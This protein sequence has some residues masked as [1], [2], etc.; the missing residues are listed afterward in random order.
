MVPV[1]P[2]VGSQISL[3]V[4]HLLR[5]R[6]DLT[7]LLASRAIIP[8]AHVMPHFLSVMPDFLLALPDII[9]VVLHIVR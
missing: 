5:P 6:V 7:A 8:V 4:P 1:I 9:S 2:L 3:I